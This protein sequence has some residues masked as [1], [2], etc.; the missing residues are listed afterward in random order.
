MHLEA[1]PSSVNNDNDNGN[2]NTIPCPADRS[3]G[4]AVAEPWVVG[5]PVVISP[6]HDGDVM[7]LGPGA[8]LPLAASGRPRVLY[9]A[10]G[11]V[12]VRVGIT[13]HML[14]A[15]GALAIAPERPV[16]VI[17]H[18]EN[19]AKVFLLTLPAPRIQWRLIPP[20]AFATQ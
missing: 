5:K 10:S 14:A 12:T 3:G 18:T 11:G 20:D 16:A 15:D 17:N 6:E 9:V 8:E 1:R 2:G 4:G 13:H 7:H 19:P